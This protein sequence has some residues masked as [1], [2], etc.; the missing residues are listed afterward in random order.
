MSEYGPVRAGYEID[1]LTKV[2][3]EMGLVRTSASEAPKRRGPDT[4]AGE[5][6]RYIE[7]AEE[8]GLPGSR[9]RASSER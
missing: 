5:V 3:E 6:D 7:M 9:R 8:L 1:R 2:A 4:A